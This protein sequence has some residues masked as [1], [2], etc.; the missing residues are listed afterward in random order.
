MLQQYHKSSAFECLIEGCFMNPLFANED[1]DPFI[2]PQDDNPQGDM[3]DPATGKPMAPE[4]SAV[5]PQEMSE[6]GQAGRGVQGSKKATGEQSSDDVTRKEYPLWYLIADALG[7]TVEPFDVYQ[8]P[9]ITVPGN[10]G[11]LFIVT[12][13]GLTAQ[14]WN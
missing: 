4:P 5:R 7:G 9:Y 3:L 11:R 12:E 6:Q 10:E 14:V 13:D 8:G 2:L 1:Q